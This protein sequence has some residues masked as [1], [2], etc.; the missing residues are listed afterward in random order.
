MLENGD[1]QGKEERDKEKR[2]IGLYGEMSLAMALHGKGWQVYKAYIDEHVDFIIAR[3]YCTNCQKF[4]YLHKRPSES[5]SRAL[6][7]NLFPTN[8]CQTCQKDTIKFIVRFLQVKTS[9]GIPAIYR[10]QS[11]KDCSF[12]AKLRSNVDNRA[13]YVWIY[14]AGEKKKT[15]SHYYIFHHTEINKFDDLTL[16]SYQRTDNQ[17]TT[18]HINHLGE[19]LNEGR[20]YNFSCFNSDFRDNF[21]KFDKILD[22][23]K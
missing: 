3:Y 2:V 8:L 19:V 7:S 1:K 20:K 16:D 22:E 17:K 18:L 14:L 4:S 5:T 23:E 21:D 11:V 12:H 10:S 13:F 9:R 15:V 6:I